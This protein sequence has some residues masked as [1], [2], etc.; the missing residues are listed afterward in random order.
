MEDE[1]SPSNIHT[2]AVVCKA[3]KFMKSIRE[4]IPSMEDIGP[5]GAASMIHDNRSS[6]IKVQEVVLDHFSC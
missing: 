5:G 4:A 3:E 6:Y 2:I 1:H